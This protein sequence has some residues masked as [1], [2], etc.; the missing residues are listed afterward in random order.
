MDRLDELAD[1]ALAAAKQH[2]ALYAWALDGIANFPWQRFFLSPGFGGLAAVLA[3][4]I[5]FEGLRRSVKAQRETARKEQWW[6][7]ARWAL[8]LTLSDQSSTR[9]VGYGV[10][11]ALAE[12]EYAAEHEAE[13]IDAALERGIGAYDPEDGLDESSETLGDGDADEPSESGT[14]PDET[15]PTRPRGAE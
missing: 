9:E 6:D 3:A 1:L 10:L 7:R 12:S 4:S 11:E 2:V 15:G 5:A 13:V 8:D 14:E